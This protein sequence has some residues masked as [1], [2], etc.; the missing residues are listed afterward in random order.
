MEKKIYIDQNADGKIAEVSNALKLVGLGDFAE[1][2]Y[3]A[4]IYLL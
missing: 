2:Y 4:E 3:V 1:Y